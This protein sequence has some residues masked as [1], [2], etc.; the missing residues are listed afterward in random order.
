MLM[1]ELVAEINVAASS[2]V[3]LRVPENISRERLIRA[4][5]EEDANVL[6]DVKIFA[7]DNEP[8]WRHVM[9]RPDGRR[10]S[11]MSLAEYWLCRGLYPAP[12]SRPGYR[13]AWRSRLAFRAV[14]EGFERGGALYLAQL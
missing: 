9:W 1:F 2:R 11:A 13:K 6:F 8:G 12:A 4:L 5:D 14:A 10:K 7:Q 3:V